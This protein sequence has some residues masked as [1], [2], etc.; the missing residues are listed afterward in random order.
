MSSKAFII[1]LYGVA[2]SIIVKRWY[3]NGNTGLPS[4]DVI[5]APSYLYGVLALTSDFLEGLPVVLAAGLTAGLYYATHNAS[6]AVPSGKRT[7]VS[8]SPRTP[9][10][11]VPTKKGQ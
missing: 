4:P 2:L 1:F 5:T 3:G 7:G 6:K 11:G 10:T 9:V 8:K